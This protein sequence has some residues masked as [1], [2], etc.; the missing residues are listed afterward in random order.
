MLAICLVLAALTLHLGVVQSH[1]VI[2]YPPWRGNNLI[3]NGTKPEHDML[4]TGENYVDGQKTFPYGGFSKDFA[5]EIL[6]ISQQWMYP[7][8]GMPMST[9]RS[10]W[11]VSGGALALQPGWFSGHKTAMFYVNIG[12]NE[13]GDV[14]PPNMSHPVAGP[15]Q[16]T[17]PTNVEYPGSFC[18]PQVPLVPG[19]TFNIGDN[20]TIQVIELAQHGAAIYNCADVTLADPADVPEVNASNCFN[21]S[22]LSFQLV[23]ATGNL[24]SSALPAF[25]PSSPM[26]LTLPLLVA[27]FAFVLW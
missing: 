27:I 22:D 13:P 10:L 17:G 16:I 12:I 3:T 26:S 23:Y 14:A 21:S 24:S 8:G 1:T 7:C 19:V 11:P 18:L 9:N 25:T 5:D 4:A 20:V 6:S 2:T 15:F